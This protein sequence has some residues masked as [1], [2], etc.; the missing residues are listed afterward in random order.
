[1]KI[2]G[3]H[4]VKKFI[5]HFKRSGTGEISGKKIIEEEKKIKES[6]FWGQGQNIVTESIIAKTN[7]ESSSSNGGGGGVYCSGPWK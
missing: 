4:K 6:I 2:S 7:R 3:I 5:L 1:M